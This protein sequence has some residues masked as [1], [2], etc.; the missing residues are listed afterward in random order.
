MIEYEEY[1]WREGITAPVQN[2]HLTVVIYDISDNKVRYRM[3]KVLERYGKRIQ[4]SAFEAYINKKQFDK[5]KLEIGKVIRK[6]DKVKI[7]R[8]RGVSEVCS[9]G[10]METM[11]NEEVIVI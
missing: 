11:E 4:R 7:Y 8:L 9:Y 10:E 1:I 2:K 5:L 3:A 6:E